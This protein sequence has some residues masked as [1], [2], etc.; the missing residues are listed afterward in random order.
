M[1]RA[2]LA[3]ALSLGASL[4]ACSSLLGL[5][6][7][8]LDNSV[9][10]DGSTTTN[11]GST[12]TD[13][14]ASE[15][16]SSCPG[17]DTTSDPKNCGACGHDCLGGACTASACQPVL[18][19][20]DAVN[21]AP[22]FMTEDSTTIYFS[23]AQ[24]NLLISN[25]AKVSKSSIDGSVP[26]QILGKFGDPGGGNTKVI[27]PL[28]V[29]LSGTN[30]YVALSAEEYNMTNGEFLGGVAQCDVTAGCPGGSPSDDL[31]IKNIDSDALYASNS[32]LIYGWEDL[33]DGGVG[34]DHYLLKGQLPIGSTDTTLIP[35]TAQAEFIVID[36]KENIYVATADGIFT[37]DFVSTVKPKVTSVEAEQLA[38]YNDTIY[39]TSAPT[40]PDGGVNPPATVQSVPTS[41]GTPTVLATGSFL[42]VPAGIAV[43]T[44]YIYI[45]DEGD[46]GVQSDGHIYRC[47]LSGCGEDGGAA[48]VLSTGASSGNNPRTIL[49]GDTDAIYWGNRYGQIWKLAK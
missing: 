41:G 7:P 33:Q 28:Q 49:A 42:S 24:S 9:G 17:V 39:F 25:V 4:V 35:L 27:Y 22:R 5:T 15:A 43:D 21:L 30:L 40:N 8:T 23:N 18:I 29:V 14:P 13:G 44:N 31:Y 26:Y 32:N 45:A 34:S 48:T 38:V 47:P 36:S 20:D 19:V 12:S 46:L 2:R 6:D 37:T 3:L 1:R 10:A 16:A 11:E